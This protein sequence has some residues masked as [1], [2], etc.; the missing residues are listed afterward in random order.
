MALCRAHAHRSD[1]AQATAQL[2]G[3]GW[4]LLSVLYWEWDALGSKAAKQDCRSICRGRS[5]GWGTH[6]GGAE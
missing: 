5:R 6:G 3:A 4:A 1:G 2:Q